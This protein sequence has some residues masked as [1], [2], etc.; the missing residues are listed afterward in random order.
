MFR[1]GVG[2]YRLGLAMVLVGSSCSIAQ[3]GVTFEIS[4]VA[5][6]NTEVPGLGGIEF[7]FLRNAEYAVNGG[8]V[9][10]WGRADNF[11]TVYNGL[12]VWENGALSIVVDSDTIAPGSST[13]FG[14]EF[15]TQIEGDSV[16]FDAVL[17]FSGPESGA[18]VRD[19]TSL[20]R[21]AD[22]TQT[23]P[24]ASGPG[25]TGSPR[26]HGDSVM[27][28]S[29]DAAGID[30]VYNASIETGD[31]SLVLDEA[32]IVP[33]GAGVALGG[34]DGNRLAMRAIRSTGIGE[35]VFTTDVAGD[36][37][38]IALRGD[39]IPNG[40]GATFTDFGGIITHPG[41]D[42]GVVVFTG[43]GGGVRGIYTAPTTGGPLSIV[44]DSTMTL[45]DGAPASD[46]TAPAISNSNIAFLGGGMF[47]GGYFV[48]WEGVVYEVAHTGDV[49]DGRTIQSLVASP[50]G[51]DGRDLA[52]GVRFTD[53][54]DAIYL[55]HIIPAP[56][57]ALLL[58]APVMLVGAARRRGR[59][60]RFGSGRGL[61]TA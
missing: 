32:A 51:F 34:F 2:A 46:L 19:T 50:F 21:I 11:A 15:D 48:R 12:F 23:L 40:D 61:R 5:D 28:L 37:R 16:V 30:R 54:T 35:G 7:D 58:G 59:S 29:R 1:S 57:A 44:I 43:R 56:S 4:K 31:V 52:F 39:P 26:L 60:L 55:A 33:P 42:N 38:T 13:H 49:L 25:P 18:Y 53:N 47:T 9:A 22:S 36:V 3:A 24:G 41:V 17:G 8:R 6:F 45:P 20:R 14:A 10:F 27:F